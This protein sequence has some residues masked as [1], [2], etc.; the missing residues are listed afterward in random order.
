MVFSRNYIAEGSF[1]VVNKVSF[2]SKDED[3][4]Q[5][6]FIIAVKAKVTS[7]NNAGNFSQTIDYFVNEMGGEKRINGAEENGATDRRVSEHSS[8]LKNVSKKLE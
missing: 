4:Q 6:S 5:P 3:Y 7:T 1:D 8:F 2:L